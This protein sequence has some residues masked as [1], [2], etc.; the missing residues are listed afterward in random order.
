MVG[1]GQG[2]FIGAVHRMA[3]FIDGEIELVCGAFSSNQERSIN[4]GISFNLPENRCYACF[5]EMFMRE[6]LLPEDERMDFVAIV[7]PNH[8]HFPIA[9][10]AIEHAFM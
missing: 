9:K 2:A 10:A 8:L 6:A 3:A 7:T 5:D 1:G 4:S